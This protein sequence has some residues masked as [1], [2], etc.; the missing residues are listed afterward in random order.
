MIHLILAAT[1]LQGGAVAQE[2]LKRGR[3][4]RVLTWRA[5]SPKA[6]ALA[7][8][9]AEVVEGDLSQPDARYRALR[10]AGQ[11][12]AINMEAGPEQ[13]RG[14]ARGCRRGVGGSR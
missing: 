8:Q 7:E 13:D 11:R 12:S 2:M 14:R 3:S 10:H 6:K 4:V 1:G 5:S 9:G